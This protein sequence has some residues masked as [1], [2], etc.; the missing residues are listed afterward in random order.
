MGELPLSFSLIQTNLLTI[1][2]LFPYPL[3]LITYSVKMWI[4]H[5]SSYKLQTYL[6]SEN[7]TYKQ[8]QLLFSLRT[9]SIDVKRN[10]KNKYRNS[11]L[12]CTLCDDKLV[13]SESHLLE[14]TSTYE[15]LGNIG[16]AKYEDIFSSEISSVSSK[17]SW[18]VIFTS[19]TK[20]FA[21][22]N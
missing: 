1:C 9:R 4:F 7:L 10:Y 18:D 17:L 20:T 22:H 5:L 21:W 14:C 19:A 2:L 12:F 13:E 3:L 16:D 15:M 8:K 6:E 11:N